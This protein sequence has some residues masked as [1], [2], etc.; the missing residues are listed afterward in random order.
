MA[1]TERVS[2]RLWNP[3]GRKSVPRGQPA[4]KGRADFELL[5]LVSVPSDP[6]SAPRFPH[7]TAPVTPTAHAQ[8]E[9]EALYTHA[10]LASIPNLPERQR[11]WKATGLLTLRDLE[12]VSLPAQLFADVA[13][14]RTVCSSCLHC[15]CRSVQSTPFPLSHVQDQAANTQIRSIDLTGN[16]LSSL[17]HTMALLQGCTQVTA[18][19]D[20]FLG[21][22]SSFLHMVPPAVALMRQDSA[23]REL[24]TTGVSLVMLGQDKGP[25]CA[26]RS[27]LCTDK[28]PV[29]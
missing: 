23:R 4:R 29:G 24:D 12:L 18:Q 11:A 25:D 28:L 15:S 7:G 22:P 26:P 6:P 5:Y 20:L 3:A 21:S 1:V 19:A 14:V 27:T 16:N 17:P 2:A 8:A 13:Q 9:T 10:G